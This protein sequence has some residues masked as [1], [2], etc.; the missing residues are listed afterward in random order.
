MSPK[1][2]G[3]PVNGNGSGG[4]R[5]KFRF[6]DIEMENVNES[7]TEGLKSLAAALSRS[8]PQHASVRALARATQATL[9]SS[10]AADSLEV[11]EEAEEQELEP[12]LPEEEFVDAIDQAESQPPASSKPRKFKA[13]DFLRDVDLTGASTPLEAYL[14]QKNPTSTQDKYLV[15]AQWFKEFM[16]IEE[17]NMNHVYTAYDTLKWRAQMPQDANA[18]FRWLKHDNLVDSGSARG[19]YKINWKGIKSVAAMGPTE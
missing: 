17:I 3:K 8:G 19:T 13:P 12:Q 6:V 16:G 9:R 14:A 2:S 15:I 10:S 7:I 18:P 5:I 11:E 4:G 1:G